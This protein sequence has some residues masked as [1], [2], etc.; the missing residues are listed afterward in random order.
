ME[1][2]RAMRRPL[3]SPFRFKIGFILLSLTALLSAEKWLN[4]AVRFD[5]RSFGKDD[6]TR[7]ERRFQDLKKMLP[8]QGVVGYLTDDHVPGQQTRRED[9]T[10]TRF[11]LTQYALAP[12]IVV[13]TPD[14]SLVVGDF[15]E[16]NFAST[17]AA[18]KNLKVLVNYSLLG[19][20][21]VVLLYNEEMR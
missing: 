20:R 8:S 19:D 5:P 12:L 6:V 21:G 14:C 11:F 15:H 18:H 7:Y 1:W 2:R 17:I 16:A 10:A 4:E 9:Q 13:G 3:N